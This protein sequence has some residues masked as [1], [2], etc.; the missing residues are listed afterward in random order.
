MMIAKE[1]EL[2]SRLS[3]A[4]EGGRAEE[5]QRAREALRQFYARQARSLPVANDNLVRFV[6]LSA[7]HPT[8][9]GSGAALL[10]NYQGVGE[11]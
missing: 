6:K 3:N 1:R 9:C 2:L 11:R 7:R 4:I 8:M 5:L 10:S